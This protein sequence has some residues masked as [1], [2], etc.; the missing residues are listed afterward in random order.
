MVA[1]KHVAKDREEDKDSS[2]RT[3]GVENTAP[4]GETAR[5]ADARQNELMN[6]PPPLAHVNPVTGEVLSQPLDTGKEAN[7]NTIPGDGGV[8]DARPNNGQVNTGN[9]NTDK[10]KS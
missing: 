5:Q 4:L 2:L 3:A 7:R 6:N 1:K 8:K 10:A 9:P